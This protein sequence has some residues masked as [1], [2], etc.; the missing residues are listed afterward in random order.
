MSSRRRS[1][2]ARGLGLAALTLAA[3]TPA[4]AGEA[5]CLREAAY[6]Q[7]GSRMAGKPSP[8]PDGLA[9]PESLPVSGGA[10]LC[11]YRIPARGLSPGQPARG[12][13]LFVQGSGMLASR[14][15]PRLQPFAELGLDVYAYDFRGY[16]CSTGTPLAADLFA[17]AKA[18]LAH[19]DGRYPGGVHALYG[20]SWGGIVLANAVEPARPFSVLALDS[21]PDRLPF[22]FFCPAEIYP[23][24][25]LE[26][27]GFDL[28]RLLLVTNG[29]DP[30]VK[31][32][33]M[34]GLLG[35]RGGGRAP[36]TEELAALAHPFSPDDDIPLRVA[37][38][39]RR[40]AE[41]AGLPRPE[42]TR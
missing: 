11:G 41:I 42:E 33:N 20:V 17:D 27:P 9:R 31:P 13:L 36:K 38:L 34:S 12:Y 7:G 21:V 18:L 37:T 26:R 3:S 30:K 19:L 28:S 14:V 32:R 35:L 2:L 5:M 25:R 16:G 10:T 23:V 15:V 39:A 40:I 4:R 8:V 6:F 24:R 22:F 1:A 29:E